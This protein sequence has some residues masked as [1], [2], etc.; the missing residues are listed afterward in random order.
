MTSKKTSRPVFDASAVLALI[1]GEPGWELLQPLQPH[2]VVNSVNAAEVLAKLVTRG[3]PASA[4]LAAFEALHLEVTPFEPVMA[5]KSVQFVRK[6]I[7][8]GDRCFLAAC[9]HGIG[10]TSDR[11]MKQLAIDTGGP[12]LKF[13]R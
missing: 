4:A 7:S 10:W 3:M 1:Q 12:D 13:F 5:S 9:A 8:L 2:A 11:G 6:G